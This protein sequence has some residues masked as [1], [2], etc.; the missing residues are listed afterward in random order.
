MEM[1]LAVEALHQLGYI[2][3]DLKPD[4]FLVDRSGHLKLIDFGLSQDGMQQ[5]YQGTFTMK[6]LSLSKSPS[7]S[8]S[9]TKVSSR[10]FS[11]HRKTYRTQRKAYSIVGSPEYMA[12]EILEEVGYNHTVDYW[13]LGII[14]YEL[15]YGITPFTSDSVDETFQK[16]S[17]WK[18]FVL[19][20]E[21]LEDEADIVV[22][23]VAWD[24]IVHL[25]EEPALRLGKNDVNEI[26]RHSFCQGI[27]WTLMIE[28]EPPFVPSLDDELD[29][30]YY[31]NALNDADF[32]SLSVDELDIAQ[33]LKARIQDP[34]KLPLHLMAINPKPEQDVKSAA[35]HFSNSWERAAFAGWTY[36]HSDLDHLL[37]RLEDS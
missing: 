8:T 28:A 21:P 7:P 26:K 16:L 15:L 20:P 36:K 4:N 35:T 31:S 12:I 33:L 24:L 23:N 14:L 17:T 22:S 30:S 19:P 6:I 10:H 9:T 29:T 18:E 13:S 37:D 32:A 11:D 25:L 2:H 5:K 34:D 27:K 1:L 3:R